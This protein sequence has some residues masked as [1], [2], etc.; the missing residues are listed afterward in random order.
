MYWCN[1]VILSLLSFSSV[2]RYCPF[3]FFNSSSW[4]SN[5]NWTMITRFLREFVLSWLILM[6][7]SIAFLTYLSSSGWAKYWAH[8]HFY[9]LMLRLINLF[10]YYYLFS[11]VKKAISLSAHTLPLK[12]LFRVTSSFY[13]ITCFLTKSSYLVTLSFNC[14][15]IPCAISLNFLV[16][17]CHSLII[18]WLLS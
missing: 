18:I 1:L 2:F 5:L 16:M 11:F 4:I 15:W 13:I 3:R 17:S 7:D 6:S 8:N 14:F 9:T 10:L 12:A